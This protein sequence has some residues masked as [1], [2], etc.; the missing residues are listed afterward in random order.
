[1]TS[2]YPRHELELYKLSWE[3]QNDFRDWLVLCPCSMVD[4]VSDGHGHI[5][6]II[7]EGGP[8]LEICAFYRLQLGTNE[9][10]K[11]CLIGPSPSGHTL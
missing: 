1:M 3:R 10:W 8:S 9:S 5:L 4:H 6:H 11:R 2:I 7:Q